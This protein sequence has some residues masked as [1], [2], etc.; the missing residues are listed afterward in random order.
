MGIF[1]KVIESGKLIDNI[2]G[3]VIIFSLKCWT[4]VID[5]S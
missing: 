4:W 5:F 3:P 2:H 1:F